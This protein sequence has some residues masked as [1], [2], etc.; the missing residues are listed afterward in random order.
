M[1]NRLLETP[2]PE[3]DKAL[4]DAIKAIGDKPPEPEPFDSTAVAIFT[5]ARNLEKPT[6]DQM[7]HLATLISALKPRPPRH[8]ELQTIALIG[9]LPAEQVNRWPDGT[10]AL[11]LAVTRD[12]E[13]AAAIDG[14]CLP[15]VRSA[16]AKADASRRDALRD[17]CN[18][19]N[20]NAMREK[21]I[22]ALDAAGRDYRAV[23]AAAGALA[24]AF[25]E[26]E[27]TRAVLV[28][29]A[30]SFPF[31]ALPLSEELGRRWSGLADDFGKLQQLL[32]APPHRRCRMGPSW[33][34]PRNRPWLAA[35]S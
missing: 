13:D 9:G 23:R 30:V 27:E 20:T 7:K 21:A 18:L 26:Y 1:F 4:L 32:R 14:R 31:E 15:W 10:I 6:H 2:G 5:F 35:S 33:N 22:A 16:L 11:L 12:A 24:S 19:R 8:A 25:R 3:R 29:L 34:E 28:D 17:L